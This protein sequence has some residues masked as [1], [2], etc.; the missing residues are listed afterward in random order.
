MAIRNYIAALVTASMCA[1]PI[2]AAPMAAADTSAETHQVQQD[3]QIQHDLTP[4]T[5]LVAVPQTKAKPSSSLTPRSNARHHH[6]V[7]FG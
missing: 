1:L 7:S 3:Q 5:G 2:A 6:N 4:R